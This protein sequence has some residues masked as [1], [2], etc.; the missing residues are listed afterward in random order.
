MSTNH[1]NNAWVSD[2]RQ[3]GITMPIKEAKGRL[4]KVVYI[5]SAEPVR[6]RGRV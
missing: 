4:Q 6:E 1:E 3:T 5:A 2:L